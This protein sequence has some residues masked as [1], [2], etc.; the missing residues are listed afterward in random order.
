MLAFKH[1]LVVATESNAH[2]Q[3]ANHAD[4]SSCV[5]IA[6]RLGG[7][8]PRVPGRLRHRPLLAPGNTD[9]RKSI[10]FVPE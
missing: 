9:D 2:V 4:R 5:E 7:P 8:F 1:E 3:N 10:S 6:S